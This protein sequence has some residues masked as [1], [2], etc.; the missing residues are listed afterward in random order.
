MS[1]RAISLAAVLLAASSAIASARPHCDDQGFA[2][3]GGQ[4]IASS[5]CE[6]QLA[7]RVSSR[8][9]GGYTAAQLRN[10]P[11]AME[12]FCRGNNDIRFTDACASQKD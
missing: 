6:A 8:R 1:V 12:E 5:W 4:W 7:A 3:V 10:N 11:K 9:G 2:L